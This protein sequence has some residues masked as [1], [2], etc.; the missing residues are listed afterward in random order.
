[1]DNEPV[2]LSVTD[3]LL[4]GLFRLVMALPQGVPEAGAQ[5]E[6]QV[7]LL[8][9][10]GDQILDPVEALLIKI[11]VH[12]QL[13]PV[14]YGADG[15]VIMVFPAEVQKIFVQGDLQ[16]LPVLGGDVLRIDQLHQDDELCVLALLLQADGID[17]ALYGVTDHLLCG[18]DMDVGD[19]QLIEHVELVGGPGQHD[20][21]LSAFPQLLGP[22]L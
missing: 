9:Q 22:F 2:V 15:K 12:V 16:I 10:I 21:D 20:I 19:L 17:R 13:E 11:R 18:Q 4:E 7:S 5:A 1:M 6:F 14:G 3:G 8:V